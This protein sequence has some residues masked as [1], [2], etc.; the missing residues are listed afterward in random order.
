MTSYSYEHVDRAQRDIEMDYRK[1][2][3]RTLEGQRDDLIAQLKDEIASMNYDLRPQDLISGVQIAAGTLA[4][5][6][7][8]AREMDVNEEIMRTL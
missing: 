7:H 6:M 1:V 8:V 5:L 3:V 4:R 2:H